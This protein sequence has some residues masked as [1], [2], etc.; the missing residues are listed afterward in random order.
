[1]S[2]YPLD[3]WLY[4]KF[5]VYADISGIRIQHEMGHKLYSDTTSL[6]LGAMM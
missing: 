2:N 1:V 3:M 4:L 6:Y 5:S